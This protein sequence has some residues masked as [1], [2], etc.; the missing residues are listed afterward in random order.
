MN[1][2]KT[3]THPYGAAV[4]AELQNK[5]VEVYCG[6]VRT[7]LNYS[8]SDVSEKNIVCG[9]LKDVI[10]DCM[11]I[12]C[13][14]GKRCNIVFLNCWAIKSVLGVNSSDLRTHHVFTD[15]SQRMKLRNVQ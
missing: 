7:T 10:G 15:S 1:E 13:R 9:V 4:L 3:T 6:D 8:E 14:S 12:E 5:Q 11:L 2:N